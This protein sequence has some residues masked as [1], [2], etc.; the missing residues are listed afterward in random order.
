VRIQ[1]HRPPVRNASVEEDWCAWL[2]IQ[3]AEIFDSYQRQFN[4]IYG[5]FSVS[6]NEALE[7]RRVG[8]FSKSC[9]AVWVIPGICSRLAGCLSAVL[10]SLAEHARHYGTIPNAAPL[11]PINFQGNKGQRSARINDLFSRV[12]L[13]QRSQFLYKINVLSEMVQSLANDFRLAAEDLGCGASDRPAA[14]WQVVDQSHYDLNTCLRE[15]IV[16]LKSFLVILPDDQVGAFQRAVHS[17]MTSS[18]AQ[19]SHTRLP[20][21]GRMASIER[22]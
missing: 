4:L 18:Q 15:T 19:T 16:L 3:K 6:L 11:D 1:T 2:P 14:D 21:H 13:T 20:K 9:Q 8:N 7:L 17:R 12:L 22:E 5:M 10:G